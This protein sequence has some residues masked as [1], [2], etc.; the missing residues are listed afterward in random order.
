MT[1]RCDCIHTIVDCVYAHTHRHKRSHSFAVYVHTNIHTF[2]SIVAVSLF[3]CCFV[4]AYTLCADSVCVCVCMKI[5]M[6]ACV[7]NNVRH[8]RAS[9]RASKRYVRAAQWQRVFS[10]VCRLIECF[11]C[12]VVAACRCN[13]HRCS[14]A[15][16][17]AAAT[18]AAALL[19]LTRICV[20]VLFRFVSFRFFYS[21]VQQCKIEWRIL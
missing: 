20:P 9:E 5:H 7:Y 10:S 17:A 21:G 6:H 12:T 8:E 19:L 4:C 1:I 18:A 3:H 14:V 2:A 15:A 11:W 13:R 16:D